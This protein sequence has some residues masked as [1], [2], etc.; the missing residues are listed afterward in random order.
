MSI[1]TANAIWKGT[2]KDGQGQMKL[3]SGAFD[4]EFTWA[5]RFADGEGTNPEEL[6]GAAHA[7]CFSMFLSAQLTKAGYVPTHIQTAAAVDL[8]ADDVGP[9][10][11]MIELSCE[12]RVPEIEPSEFQEL[13][14]ISKEK[15]PISRALAATEFKVT[16]TLLP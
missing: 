3:G 16:A 2:L 14:E 9:M 11:T 5:S 8:G 13:V 10:I 15:C 7:G 4:G 1:R 12:A 6:I